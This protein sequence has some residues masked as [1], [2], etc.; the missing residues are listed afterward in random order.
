MA[1]GDVVKVWHDGVTIFVVVRVD[2]GGVL[3][4][5]DYTASVP[6][7]VIEAISTAADKKAALVAAVKTVRDE[8][9]KTALTDVP[10]PPGQVT[11]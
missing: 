1:T 2:E 8:R 4:V 11:L 7:A 10:V 5:V 9:I 6:K 3:G